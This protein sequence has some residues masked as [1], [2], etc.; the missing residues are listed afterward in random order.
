MSIT[1]RW[2]GFLGEAVISAGMNA[3]AAKLPLQTAMVICKPVTQTLSLAPAHCHMAL[4]GQQE[5]RAQ[6]WEAP[7]PARPPW[8]RQDLGTDPGTHPS[9][10]LKSLGPEHGSAEP[11]L[12]GRHLGG[13]HPADGEQPHMRGSSSEVRGTVSEPLQAA[14]ERSCSGLAGVQELLWTGHRSCQE[15]LTPTV[16]SWLWPAS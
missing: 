1:A 15:E 2:I 8:H 16:S 11:G 7:A 12:A 10:S 9:L 13:I 3:E 6:R 5:H 14:G 4:Q